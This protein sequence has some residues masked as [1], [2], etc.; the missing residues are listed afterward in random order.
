MWIALLDSAP[1]PDELQRLPHLLA[2]VKPS[3]EDTDLD[4]DEQRLHLALLRALLAEL[5][6]E[7]NA[8]PG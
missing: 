1:S 3:T 8:A 7:A 6:Q 2:N 5:S 4:A